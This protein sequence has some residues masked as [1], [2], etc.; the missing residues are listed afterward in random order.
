MQAIPNTPRRRLAT[1]VLNATGAAA[2]VAVSTWCAA[3]TRPEPPAA[4]VPPTVVSGPTGVTGAA[5]PV[6]PPAV[7]GTAPPRAARSDHPA[8]L[9]DAGDLTTAQG[10]V[11]RFVTNPDGDVD[12]LLTNDGVLVRVSPQMGSQL[13]SMVRPGDDVRL[14]GTRD[15][16][17]ALA[18]QRIT[19]TR[20]GQ[21]LED[22]PPVAGDRP[23]PLGPL[24]PRGGALSRLSV[25]GQVTHVT[26]A[27][28]GEPDG[29]ILADGTVIRLTP[30]IA[31]Q[32][33]SLVQTGAK[34]S[35]QGYGTRTPYGTALQ[36]TAFGSPGNLTRLYDR[37]P[38]AP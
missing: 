37:A 4:P 36:A 22:Q 29:V 18:A 33:P 24:G 7:T 16:G 20:S 35:A 14:S 1:R 10:T 31:Q 11:A 9:A 3:Q 38:P 13:T 25:Q 17:G 32:F 23:P 28:R 19:D 8:L 27:P 5:S 26:T 21:Q 12:G 34:V 15:A 30:P 2:L 6:P